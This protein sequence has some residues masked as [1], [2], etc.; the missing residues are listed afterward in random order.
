MNYINNDIEILNL[1]DLGHLKYK[2]IQKYMHFIQ[3]LE[4]GIKISYQDILEI[5]SLIDVYSELDNKRIYYKDYYLNG[6]SI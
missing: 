2:A 1:D 3:C 6:Y 4:K 5:I